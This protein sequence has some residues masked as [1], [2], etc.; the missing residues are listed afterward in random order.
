M[1]KQGLS[2]TWWYSIELYYISDSINAYRNKGENE[3]S[4]YWFIKGRR[5]NELQL[6][7]IT[8]RT[9][10]LTE[11]IAT[12][13][14]GFRRIIFLLPIPSAR[15]WC[16][17]ARDQTRYLLHHR[18]MPTTGSFRYSIFIGCG[19]FSSPFLNFWGVSHRVVWLGASQLYGEITINCNACSKITRHVYQKVNFI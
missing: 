8:H 16:N 17:A 11:F 15:L 12:M 13:V 4:L 14:Q 9:S 3:I 19:S 10:F 6:T 1:F 7:L 5:W 18:Q 2:Q